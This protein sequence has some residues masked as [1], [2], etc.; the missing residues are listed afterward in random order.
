MITNALLTELVTQEE[1][2]HNE[3]KLYIDKSS[4]VLCMNKLT[5]AH[6]CI[7]VMRKFILISWTTCHLSNEIPLPED[8]DRGQSKGTAQP[9]QTFSQT[10]RNHH[11]NTLMK[12]YDETRRTIN[13]RKIQIHSAS[14]RRYISY[15]RSAL[16][17]CTVRK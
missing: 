5:Y 6:N 2:L 11:K 9:N 7:K 16:L 12:S 10:N 4:P 17:N 13:N 1:A 15:L 14:S 3:K 8:A